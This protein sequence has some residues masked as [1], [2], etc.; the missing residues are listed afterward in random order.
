[1]TRLDSVIFYQRAI[2]SLSYERSIGLLY[3]LVTSHTIHWFYILNLDSA[4][5]TP[6]SSKAVLARE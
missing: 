4:I 1:M 5:D 6:S 2:S 3:N